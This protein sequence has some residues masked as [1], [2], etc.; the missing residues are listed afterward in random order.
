MPALFGNPKAASKIA[1]EAL[2]TMHD[3]IQVKT[4]NEQ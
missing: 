2:K 1:G 3:Y 4:L